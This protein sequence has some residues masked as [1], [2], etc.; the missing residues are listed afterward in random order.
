M[1]PGVHYRAGDVAT[2]RDGVADELQLLPG[3]QLSD[4]DVSRRVHVAFA[5]PVVSVDR[6]VVAVLLL[7]ESEVAVRVRVDGDVKVGVAPHADKHA[8]HADVGRVVPDDAAGDDVRGNS[9]AYE[10]GGLAPL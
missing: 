8:R 7:A 1:D 10:V 6:V 9:G 3:A 5:S 2:A 4:R